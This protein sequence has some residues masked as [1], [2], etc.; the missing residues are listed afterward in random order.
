MVLQGVDVDDL[1]GC[2]K[3]D[4][5]VAGTEVVQHQ[6]QQVCFVLDNGH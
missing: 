1:T 3:D 4:V 6:N 2:L 5:M